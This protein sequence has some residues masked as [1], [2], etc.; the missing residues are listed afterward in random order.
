MNFNSLDINKI[1]SYAWN[2]KLRSYTPNHMLGLNWLYLE[3]NCTKY[4]LFGS[5]ILFN[6]RPFH[7]L[8]LGD[9]SWNGLL[10]ISRFPHCCNILPVDV[11]SELVKGFSICF[12]VIEIS[13]SLAWALAFGIKLFVWH[14]KCDI[15]FQKFNIWRGD[16]WILCDIYNKSE[17]SDNVRLKK[18]KPVFLCYNKL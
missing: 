7:Q 8:P 6:P 2:T 17:N 1:L 16:N 13:G 5:L 18:R 11:S 9:P 14:A 10:C 12:E 15:P 4:I 3:Q